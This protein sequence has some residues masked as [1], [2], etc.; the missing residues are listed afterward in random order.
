MSSIIFE[1]YKFGTWNQDLFD[2]YDELSY[3]RPWKRKIF[4][5]EGF[6]Y[7]IFNSNTLVDKFITLDS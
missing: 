4:A 6:C 7:N 5:E 3:S 2:G 1:V